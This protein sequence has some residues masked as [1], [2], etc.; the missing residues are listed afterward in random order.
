M[1]VLKNISKEYKTTNSQFVA[2]HDISLSFK[3]SG[4]VFITGKSGSGKSTL[5]NIIGG[6]DK[7][8]KGQIII[9]G[10]S[11]DNF[12]A[13][14][15][16]NYR[17]FQVGFI[18]QEF[19]LIDELSVKDN[20]A[21]AL[22]IQAKG[23]DFTTIDE[24]LKLV[25]LEG[26][27][28][29]S[30]KELS[31]G[32]KQRVAIARALIKNPNIILADAPTGALDSKTSYELMSSL[33]TLS[34]N[35]LVIVVTHDEEIAYEFADEIITLNDGKVI[36]HQ[37]LI[38]KYKHLQNETISKNIIKIANGNQID[39]EKIINDLL[40]NKKDHYISLIDDPTLVTISY[41][42]SYESIFKKE[43]LKERYEDYKEDD[44]TKIENETRKNNQKS[45]IAYKECLRMAFNQYK[46]KK[47]KVLFLLI[48]VIISI[49]LIGMSYS[50]SLVDN[51]KIIANTLI[52]NDTSLA[53]MERYDQN[54]KEVLSFD[55][56]AIL[57]EKYQ[58]NNFAI[59]KEMELKYTTSN[60]K[61]KS[62]FVMNNFTGVVECNDVSKLN[63]KKVAGS[64]TFNE[65]SLANN[66]IIIS[67]YAAF[68]LRRTGYLGKDQGGVYGLILPAN[69]KEQ[70][71]SQVT[72]N[73]IEY[74]IIGIFDTN[75]EKYLPLLVSE[76]YVDEQSSKSLSLNALK[77][78]Y[79]A[80]IFAPVGFY[81]N[82]ID[83]YVNL[84]SINSFA[85]DCKDVPLY[86]YDEETNTLSDNVNKL[87]NLNYNNFASFYDFDEVKANFTYTTV[88]GEVPSSLKDNQVVIS[89]DWLKQ[90]EFENQFQIDSAIEKIN[91]SSIVYRMKDMSTLGSIIYNK[92]IDVVAV[93]DIADDSAIDESAIVKKYYNDIAMM[94]SSSLKE[95]L[96]LSTY[97]Y[98]QIFF[99]LNGSRNNY[100]KTIKAMEKEH[101]SVLNINGDISFNTSSIEAYRSI[102]YIV[103]AIM[104]I[105]VLLIMTLFVSNS[106][107]DRKK[108]IGILKAVGAKTSDVLRIYLVE[109]GILALVSFIVSAI[110][111][112]VSINFINSQLGNSE[113]GI[114]LLLFNFTTL[115]VLL[116]L[117]LLLFAISTFIPVYK[118][119]KLKPIEAIRKL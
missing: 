58:D 8:D 74:K 117:T 52:N 51:S 84:D 100:V 31:G 92:G 47:G 46:H 54:G 72:I 64:L 88:W 24:A 111:V 41:P 21:L 60:N 79:F 23:H 11:T 99:T 15:F 68:E 17:N 102:G 86:S 85:I 57:E 49:C 14:D 42:D 29:R 10:K 34:L 119:A 90:F 4:M 28:Y 13:S 39:N 83:N 5:L 40:D 62:A 3:E 75:Y 35:K 37:K 6:L 73:D 63:L 59:A 108:E 77:A 110:L 53:M 48:F 16:D 12:S 89:Y 20:I 55:D 22:K 61:A 45:H 94:F 33:K 27:G 78:Y 70:I 114:Q 32:Q 93:V 1:L 56:L 82:Y 18:F 107:K 50:L 67:D 106:I 96:D 115:L 26:L 81:K 69:E 25:G 97:S 80:R 98:D 118:I 87:V 44:D 30:I 7:Q 36:S 109:E 65:N 9:D 113:I 101:Y 103:S 95:K 2:I 105:F 38:D 116:L 104:L 43:N 19:N 71:G 66:E 91:S 76:T 112:N